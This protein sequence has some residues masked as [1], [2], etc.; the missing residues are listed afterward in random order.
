IGG[1]GG[2]TKVGTGTFTL[3]GANTYAGATAINAGVLRLGTAAQRI[4][5]GSAVT[6]A[7]GA[8]FDLAGFSETGGSMADAGNVTLGGGTLTTGGNSIATTFSGVI[9]GGGGL[10]KQGAG[11]FTLS[12]TNAYTGVTIL[13]A[14]T[15]LVNG[16]LAA[17]NNVTVNGGGI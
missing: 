17:G 6:V 10:V 1:G 16:S 12:G 13:N 9:S 3:S 4:P 11:T 15:L 7:G 5:D 2:L 8:T 14:G